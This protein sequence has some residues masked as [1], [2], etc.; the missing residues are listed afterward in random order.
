MEDTLLKTNFDFLH[1]GIREMLKKF[2]EYMPLF[3]DPSIICMIIDPRY[4][5]NLIS[6]PKK[7][8]TLKMLLRLFLINI[9]QN[10]F[11][12]L[13]KMLKIINKLKIFQI[14][15]KNQDDFL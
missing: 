8:K 13:L 11:L 2:E 1:D 15:N 14:R 4:K 5:L 3:K 10:T 12:N 7:S 6:D 9:K